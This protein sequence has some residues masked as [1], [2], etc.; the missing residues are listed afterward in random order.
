MADVNRTYTA[1]EIKYLSEQIL[2]TTINTKNNL[3]PIEFILTLK[4]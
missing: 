4:R 2:L 3:F 1:T